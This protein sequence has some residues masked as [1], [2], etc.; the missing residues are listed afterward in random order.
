LDV[1][2]Q[3]PDVDRTVGVWQGTGNEDLA[4]HRAYREKIVSRDVMG[5]GL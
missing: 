4:F 1:L 3:V 2:D 5:W